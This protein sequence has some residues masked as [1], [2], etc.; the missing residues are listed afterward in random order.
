MKVQIYMKK[1]SRIQTILESMKVQTFQNSQLSNTKN[2]KFHT[3]I[4]T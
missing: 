4:Y 1:Y 2:L 3:L